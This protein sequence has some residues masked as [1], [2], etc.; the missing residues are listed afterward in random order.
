MGESVRL[1]NSRP[2]IFVVHA[3][4]VASKKWMARRRGEVESLHPL[5]M[6]Q[7]GPRL[8][9]RLSRER[10][11]TSSS[12]FRKRRAKA[13]GKSQLTAPCGAHPCITTVFDSDQR[14]FISPQSQ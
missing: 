9:I 12:D 6:G 8:D 1:S 3:V 14:L 5:E 10:R 7:P 13:D 4:H 2:S 11:S